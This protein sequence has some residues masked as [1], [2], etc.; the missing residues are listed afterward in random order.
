M[1]DAARA[2]SY[3]PVPAGDTSFLTAEVLKDQLAAG[4]ITGFQVLTVT[5][6]GGDAATVNVSYQLSGPGDAHMVT[7]TVPMI[8]KDRHWWLAD[9]A[10][11]TKVGLTRAAQRA[12]FAGAALPTGPVLLFPGALPIAFD[13]PNLELGD[14]RSSVTFTAPDNTGLTVE[15]SAAGIAAART[16]VASALTSCLADTSATVF[17]PVPGNGSSTLRAV[18]GTLRGTLPSGASDGLA[19]T[20]SPD[21]AGVLLV[22]GTVVV[23]GHYQSLDYTNIV[24]PITSDKI[25]VAIAAQCFATAASSVTW[26]AS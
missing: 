2:L 16:A 17:C 11:S 14:A 9:T 22:N 23:D 10:V 25:S 15:A 26:R 8:R 12:T 13:T 24:S 20:V 5:K 6:T 4:T 3:G 19:V 18:P 7:D 1:V 21:P